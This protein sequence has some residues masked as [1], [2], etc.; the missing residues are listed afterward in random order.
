M[1]AR[2]GYRTMLF[3]FGWVTTCLFTILPYLDRPWRRQILIVMPNFIT[4]RSTSLS[5]YTPTP[6]VIIMSLSKFYVVR[7]GSGTSLKLY[8]LIYYLWSFS[9]TGVKSAV[10]F[11]SNGKILFFSLGHI[12]CTTGTIVSPSPYPSPYCVHQQ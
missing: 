2:A 6:I 12:A 7:M 11:V 8:S 3:G 4:A 5:R 9:R 1:S 10:I